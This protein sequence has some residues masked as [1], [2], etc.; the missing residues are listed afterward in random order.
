MSDL[1]H[2][3]N[4]LQQVTRRLYLARFGRRTFIGLIACGALYLTALLIGRLTGMLPPWFETA[5]EGA[6]PLP[7]SLLSVPVGALLVGLACSRWPTPADAAREVDRRYGTKDLYLTLTMLEASAGEYKP[8]VARDA[9][10]RAAKLK[11]AEVVTLD[12]PSLQRRIA[13]SAVTVATLLLAVFYVPTLDP[14]GQQAAAKERENAAKQI[15]ETRKVNEQRKAAL[16]QKNLDNENSEDVEQAIEKLKADFQKMKAPERKPNAERLAVN[17]KSLGDKW[18]KL[19]AGELKDLLHNSDLDQRFGGKEVSEMRK[20]QRELQQ[21]SAE[22]LDQELEELKEDL[23]QLANTDDPIKRTEK[24]KQIEKR[25]RELSEFASD[26]AGSKELSAA[27]QRALDQM[28]ALKSGESQ[29]LADDAMKALQE[30]LEL[31]QAEA[32]DLAQQAR[33]L[34]SLEEAMQLISMAKQLNGQELLD[35][36]A[37]E[38]C[39]SLE[40]YAELYAQMMEGMDGEGLGGEGMGEGGV[41][42]EDDSVETDFVTEKSKSA[43]QKGKVLLSM[44]TKGLSDSGEAV[45]QYRGLVADIKQT[46]DEAIEKEDIPPGYIDGIKKYFSTI[47]KIEPELKTDEPQ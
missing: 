8:L 45:Q 27:L 22:S 44:K 41:A 19:N 43:V 36:E 4:L 37:T 3:A 7:W 20:W 6:I 16:A 5:I 46:V 34:K 18:R 12:S 13:C 26:K 24:L 33:D 21:G 9:E 31:S 42:P 28:P 23:Q 1:P 40:D 38:G 17:Q 39:Q 25:L 10:N 30:S 2:S 47:E 35:A 29:K 11:A 32:Q 14:F 15:A